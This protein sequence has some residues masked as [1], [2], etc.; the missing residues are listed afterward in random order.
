MLGL[1]LNDAPDKHSWKVMK[2]LAAHT[3]MVHSQQPL[4]QMCTASN[5]GCVITARASHVVVRRGRDDPT[6]V[7]TGCA[8]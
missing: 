6:P 2:Y 5:V 1:S 4:T 8:H 3:T 7:Y